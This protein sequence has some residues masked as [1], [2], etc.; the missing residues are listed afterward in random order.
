MAA[1]VK[2][3]AKAG[4]A[5]GFVPHVIHR[6]LLPIP[7]CVQFSLIDLDA[8]NDLLY[9]TNSNVILL[10]WFLFLI[11]RKRA[12]E[13]IIVLTSEPI[14]SNQFIIL[15]FNNLFVVCARP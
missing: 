13:E 6:P 5:Y 8:L 11:N 1:N 9:L 7:S 4:A 15:F 3:L 12:Q 10:R 2:V 14:V